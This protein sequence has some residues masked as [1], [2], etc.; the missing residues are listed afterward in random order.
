MYDDDFGL[1]RMWYQG[2]GGSPYTAC[3]AT[4]R[5]GIFWERPNLGVVEH[6]GS[7]D[8]NIFLDDACVLNVIKEPNDPDPDRR[9]KALLCEAHSPANVPGTVLLSVGCLLA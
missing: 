7:T 8:N 1:Y 9:Y 3:Y 4:S 2:Y 6:N 5:N